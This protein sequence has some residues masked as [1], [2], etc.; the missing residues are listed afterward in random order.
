MKN[1]NL[2]PREYKTLL[3]E[4][5]HRIRTAQYQAL[6]AV[7]KELIKLYWDIGKMI[8][9]KQKVKTWGKS[10]VERLAKD[11]QA[12]FQGITGFSKDNIWRMRKFYLSYKNTPKLALLVQE[13]SWT[14]NIVVLEGCKNDLEREFYLKMT[15]KFGWTK[16]V[17]IHHIENQTYEKTLLNQTSFD[18]TLSEKIKN[19][20][21]S[22]VKRDAG[23]PIGIAKYRL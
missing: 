19:Q 1:H 23:K 5:K 2:I 9:A 7:N 14:H 4:I 12:D 15:R 21:K 13:I 3:G 6:K 17:L 8:I 16:N 20:A 11:L 18:K 22:A 10:V